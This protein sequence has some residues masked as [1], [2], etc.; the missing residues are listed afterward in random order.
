MRW[1]SYF[2]LAY[3]ALGVQSGLGAF[4]QVGRATPNF[5]LLAAVFI[6]VNAPREA[7]LLGCFVLGL[8]QDLLTNSPLGLWALAY[9]VVGMF[10][11][12]SQEMVYREHFLT[13]A[14]LGFF[15]SLIAGAIYLL[16][17]WIYPMIHTSQHLSRPAIW[18]VIASAI[19][20][21]ILGP[22]VLGLLTRIKKAFAFRPGRRSLVRR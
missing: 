9:G 21:G 14:V 1:L 10:V 20:T 8:M 5:V 22:I 4:A 19:Y 18:P 13:H 12:S 2:I 16:H 11:L 17:G 7:A 6:A 15:G 3:V